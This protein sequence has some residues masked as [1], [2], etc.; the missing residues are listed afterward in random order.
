MT[1][2]DELERIAAHAP[3]VDVP[4]DT[5]ARARGARRRDLGL[6]VAGIAAALALLAGAVSWLP[7]R[8][9][10]PVASTDG[11]G[12][13]DRLYAVPER[14]SD[15]ENDGSWMRDEVTDDPTVVGVG[16]A[17]WVTDQGLPVVVG[18]SDGAYHLLDLPDF[19]GNNET[20]A[21]GLG[22][23]VVA[24]S[25]DG[26]RLAYGYAA[27]GPDAATAPIPSGIRVVDLTTG[28][29]REIPVP[30]KEGTAIDRIEWSED[31]RWLAFTGRPQ[32]TWTAGSMGSRGP[33]VIGRV[34]PGSDQAVVRAIAAADPGI[35][36]NDR[37]IV[38]LDVGT[39]KTWV[40]DTIVE[41]DAILDVPLDRRL[42]TTADGATV[43][44]LDARPQG[45]ESVVLDQ[46]G[47]TGT[48]V[49]DVP[50]GIGPS[51]SLATG[52][53]SSDDPTVSRPEPSW[54]WTDERIAISIG[55]GVAAAT[56][57]LLALLGGVRRYR[58]AR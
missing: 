39:F 30:G 29:V 49:V 8:L 20:F 13:P 24:L 4:D 27:F 1:L 54:P 31:G 37:G 41:P 2:H 32:D 6:V 53:M 51:L 57:V 46:S 15:R 11:L 52:L 45:A 18:A 43:R 56:V 10:P 21:R 3:A 26:R 23:P 48:P 28:E 34:P 58:A 25:P 5:W 36:V 17:A 35:S 50:G 22:I 16:A 19:A 12:V 9:D 55:L 7:D 14:M 44:F 33:G 42:G 47:Y 38:G 40:G